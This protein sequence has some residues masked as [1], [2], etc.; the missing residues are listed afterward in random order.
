MSQANRTNPGRGTP[1]QPGRPPASLWLASLAFLGYALIGIG[2]NAELHRI[3]WL[4]GLAGA[5]LGGVFGW[6]WQRWRRSAR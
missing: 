6:L 4:G 1:R 5:A 3:H 2:M